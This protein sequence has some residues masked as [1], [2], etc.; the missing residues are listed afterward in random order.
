MRRIVPV[1]IDTYQ[2]SPVAGAVSRSTGL[3]APVSMKLWTSVMFPAASS[4]AVRI[5]PRMKS[6]KKKR[7]RYGEG[8]DVPE[9]QVPPT[10]E[11]A[12]APGGFENTP[13][14]WFHHSCGPVGDAGSTALPK[15]E[16]LMPGG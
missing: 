11:A 9:N 14:A 4:R 6:A 13:L 15:D 16:Q 2:T 12:V 8:Y 5:Q 3:P 10:I 7:S 1:E